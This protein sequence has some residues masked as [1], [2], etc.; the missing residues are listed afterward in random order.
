[1]YP[2]LCCAVDLHGSVPICIKSHIII[3]RGKGKLHHELPFAYFIRRDCHLILHSFCKTALIC[4]NAQSNSSLLII[5]GGAKRMTVS[6]VSLQSKPFS[7][8]SSQYGRAA[9]VNSTPI[10]K[11]FPRISLIC[12]LLI[13]FNSSIIYVPN[14][15]ER[16]T[17]FSSSMTSSAAMETAQ[18]NGFPPNVDP[19]EPGLN[20]P[21]I[22]LFATM[23]EIGNTPP[24]RAF[25]RIKI[26]GDTSSQSQANIFPVR[27]S[28]T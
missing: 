19:C 26:S 14:S 13:F 27:P 7:F 9:S 17:S 20:T 4:S 1:M 3:K 10:N 2:P 21:R 16:S 12:G 11:P 5:N 22:S 8:N 28:P 15:K 24:P 23:H 6:C 18:A 25:P